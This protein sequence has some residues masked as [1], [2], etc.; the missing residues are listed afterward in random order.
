MSTDKD[1]P[2]SDRPQPAR[3]QDIKKRDDGPRPLTEDRKWQDKSSVT[4]WD[5]P[6]PPKKI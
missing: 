4:D 1:K 2:K 5:K 3:P 6:R